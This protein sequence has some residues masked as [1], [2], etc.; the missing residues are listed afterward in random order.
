MKKAIRLL[1]LTLTLAVASSPATAAEEEPSDPVMAFIE[2]LNKTC[3][4][5]ARIP[6]SVRVIGRVVKPGRYEMR[7]TDTV[8]ILLKRA[9]ID[10]EVA[11]LDQVMLIRRDRDGN[12][13]RH[14]LNWEKREE[15]GAEPLLCDGDVVFVTE[16]TE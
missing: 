2:D 8:W 3:D 7:T 11:A 13:G 4:H 1:I 10:V 9:E 15:Y 5:Q 12:E 14:V 6:A 16:R